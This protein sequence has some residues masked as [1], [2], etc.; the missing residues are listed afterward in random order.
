MEDT[1]SNN[2]RMIMPHSNNGLAKK[3]RP[4]R[5]RQVSKTGTTAQCIAQSVDAVI[6]ILS[7]L[8][9][10]FFDTMRKYIKMQHDCVF[11]FLKLHSFYSNFRETK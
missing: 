1:P 3:P 11:I 2:A 9:P 5:G 4:A 8:D 6:P 7:N 10:R